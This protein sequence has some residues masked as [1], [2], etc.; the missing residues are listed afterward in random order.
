MLARLQNSW[1]LVKESLNVLRADK[2]LLIY[3][4]LSAIGVLVVSVSF[5]VPAILSGILGVSISGESTGFTFV[6]FIVTFLFYF[7]QFFVIT[8]FNTALV[9]AAMIRLRGGD[10][11]VRDGFNVAFSRIGTILGYTAIAS[12]VGMILRAISER[13]EG[14]GRI[15][16][17]LVGMVW[18]L[19]IFLAVPVLAVEGVGPL[20]AV[21]RSAMLL[22]K[23]WG[24]QIVGNLGIGVVFGAITFGMFVVIIGGGIALSI[25]L[26]SGFIMIPAVLL[27]I[28]GGV[29]LSLLSSALNGIY[30]AAVYR[31]AAE[32]E[33]GEFFSPELV[34]GA[35]RP[36]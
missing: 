3:P 20:E 25:A 32:G 6:G 12:T 11:T 7:T 28:L 26:K 24:E 16:V 21:K 8:F 4:I 17:G 18:N 10:P 33:T 13:S 35:F 30:S 9:G 23:T 15:A 19:A 5:F 36:K 2:E 31:Y 22:K 27:M 34:Q 14:L 1:E 29:L